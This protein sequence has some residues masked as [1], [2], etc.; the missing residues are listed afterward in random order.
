MDDV[1]ET[2]TRQCSNPD[3]R[4]AQ[5]GRCVEG[6]PD[7]ESCSHYGKALVI[8]ETPNSETAKPVRSGIRLPGAEALSA[9]AAQ[10][11]LRNQPCNVIAIV[12]P[13]ES[14]K[15]SLI[16]GIYDLLQHNRIGCYAFAGT[17][18]PHAFER[19][20]HD[21]RS[22]SN[23]EDPHMERTERGDA[24]YFHLDLARVDRKGKRAALFANR[25]GEAYME[26][27]TNPDL[28]KGFAELRRCDT[29]TLLADGSKLIHDSGRHQVASD[30]CLT[31]RAFEESGQ[32]RIWQQLAIV[33][34]K[35]D[36]VRKDKANSQR[37]IRDFNRIVQDVRE[38][39]AQRFMGI[40]TFQVAASPKVDSAD[41]GEGMADLLAYWMNEPGRYKHSR[42][43]HNPKPA[44]RAFGRLRPVALGVRYA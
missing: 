16:S 42:A 29:L 9:T 12:G 22:A 18:T 28:A 20:C 44:A 2:P 3:C 5:D 15:T 38:E 11:V 17:S 31:L 41:R 36:E 25:D 7:L 37:A 32:T 34:T 13:H 6:F 23:R 14:G 43:S 10:L 30:V 4:V 33:L 27:Q 40:E 19:A 24:T 39:F 8:V 35:I 1:S 21:S 26:T